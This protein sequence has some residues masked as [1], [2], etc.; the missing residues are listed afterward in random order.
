MRTNLLFF[1]LASTLLAQSARDQRI[2]AE[3]QAMKPRL[4]ETRRDFHMHPELSNREERTARVI[5]ERL[6]AIGVDDLKTGVARHGLI[7][8]IKG[9][10]PGP[11]VAWRTDMD[12][13]PINETLD[14][15][16]KSKNAG[17]KH[18]C[19]HDGHMAVA[20]GT[21]E[22]LAKMRDQI[23]GTVKFVFQPAEEGPP[24][25]EEGGAALMV[26]EG[27]LKNPN[28][29][30]IFGLHVSPTHDA[31]T[32][33][34]NS[35]PAMS[36]SDAFIITLKGKRSHGAYPHEG[37]DAML[38]ATQCMQ[39]LYA[40]RSRRVDGQEPTVLGL[41]TI[42]GGDRYNVVAGEVKIEGTLRTFSEKVRED[43]RTKMRQVLTGC[44]A[45]Q[46]GSFDLTWRN[47]GTP[48]VV[49]PPA[50]AAA[51]AP[52]LERVA[53]KSKVIV[54][55][56]AMVS[57][58]FSW[59]QREI[60]GFFFWLGIRNESRGITAGLHTAEMDMD[61]DALVV[62]VRAAATTLLDYLDRGK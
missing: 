49:N 15:P 46:D 31:G 53:G 41:G 50:L 24:L 27:A 35:G 22:L 7:A 47:T 10:Q 61:E 21:V 23:K 8:I 52:S 40:I 37:N 57:E 60:P 42:Q 34:Y 45:M 55:R 43:I 33:G 2:A 54:G 36:S 28:V 51:T 38:M 4:I 48:A 56:P 1:V 14:V 16:Y 3:A 17:V 32:L 26:K 13:L 19:G 29:D 59:F 20:L 5:A 6:K 12:A 25:G 30:A 44:T 18:A 9:K 58:D 62:G 11:V 39:G